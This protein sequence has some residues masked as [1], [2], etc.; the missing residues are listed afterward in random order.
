MRSSTIARPN[1]DCAVLSRR[2]VA[3]AIAWLNCLEAKDRSEATNV[4]STSC[5][6]SAEVEID[7][8]DIDE[9]S[10]VPFGNG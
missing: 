6:G 2:A 8:K 10:A 7:S 1:S 9:M 4:Q 3:A 5:R